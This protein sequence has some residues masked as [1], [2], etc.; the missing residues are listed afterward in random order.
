[1]LGALEGHC[2][3]DNE[4]LCVQVAL[5]DSC[6][7]R[8]QRLEKSAPYLPARRVILPSG[9]HGKFSP[10]GLQFLVVFDPAFFEITN[11]SSRYTEIHA[12]LDLKK[13]LQK[14]RPESAFQVGDSQLKAIR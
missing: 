3:I 6:E 4:P 13:S 14:P 12:A 11:Y 10:S 9:H 5:T 2:L 1:M 7:F 8:V